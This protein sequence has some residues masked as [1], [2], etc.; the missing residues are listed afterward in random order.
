MIV[1]S[2]CSRSA[3]FKAQPEAGQPIVRAINSYYKQTGNFP[4]SLAALMPQ[5]LPTVPDRRD[6]LQHKFSGWDY[7]LVTNGKTVSFRLRYY[8]GRGGVEYQPPNWI[9]N[10]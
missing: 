1:L 4:P 7:C 2:G 3:E 8:M 9:G 5:Y 6:K 10:D